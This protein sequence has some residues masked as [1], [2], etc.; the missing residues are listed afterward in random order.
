T[1]SHFAYFHICKRKLWLFHSQVSMEQTSDIVYEGKLI[2][3]TTYTQRPEKYT[4]IEISID[5]E[6][7]GLNAKIDFYEANHKIVHEIKKSNKLENAHIAQVK[8]Y[9]FLLEKNGIEGA[10]GVLEYPKLKQKHTIDPLKED[11]RTEI[12][13]AIQAI[14]TI[15]NQEFCPE[16]VKKTYCKTCSYYDFCYINE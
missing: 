6:S 2:G 12:K 10:S 3:E 8:F 5:F 14:K 13:N 4:E 1:A 15:L 9:L 7:I 11:D 16:L